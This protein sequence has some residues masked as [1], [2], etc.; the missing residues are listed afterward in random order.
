MVSPGHHVEL[1][2]YHQFIGVFIT[3]YALLTGDDRPR[4][5]RETVIRLYTRVPT[6][7]NIARKL[8][9]R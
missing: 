7:T 4:H 2:S 5:V 8:C 3:G 9:I 1:L 6:R